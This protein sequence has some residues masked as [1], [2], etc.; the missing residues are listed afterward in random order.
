MSLACLAS[1]VG[2]HCCSSE[3]LEAG[4]E[5][6]RCLTW[7]TYA[8]ILTLLLSLKGLKNECIICYDLNRPTHSPR[9]VQVLSPSPLECDLI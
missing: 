7:V 4:R 9:Y 6:L 2:L 5:G 8:L 3:W 1:P